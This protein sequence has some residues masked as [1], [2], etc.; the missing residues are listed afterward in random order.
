LRRVGGAERSRA[1]GVESPRPRSKTLGEVLKG[2][3][4]RGS[5]AVV[6][7]KNQERLTFGWWAILVSEQ[8]GGP[9]GKKKYR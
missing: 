6:K 4:K 2:G 9:V 7:V 1:G 5:R 8:K 3:S